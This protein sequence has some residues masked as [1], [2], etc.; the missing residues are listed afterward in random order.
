M[1]LLS[2]MLCGDLQGLLYVF[3]NGN[4]GHHDDELT[5]AKLLVH[6]EN[7]FNVAVAF[8]RTDRYFNINVECRTGLIAARPGFTGTCRVSLQS[9]WLQQIAS[10]LHLVHTAQEL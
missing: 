6:L 7:S 5:P 8:T 9:L 1:V 3:T 4:A 2:K 10:F